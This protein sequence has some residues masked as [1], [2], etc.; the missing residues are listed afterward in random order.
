M[1]LRRGRARAEVMGDINVVSLID[2]MMLLLV[3]FMITA[4]MMQGGIDLTLPTA[5][6][7]PLEAKSS[8]IVSVTRTSVFVDQ[9]ELSDGEFR[10]AFKSMA[11]KRAKDG[12]YLRGD[13]NVTLQRLLNIFSIMRAAGV[14]NI[15]IITEPP[16]EG[17][18]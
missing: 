12:V 6:A 7:K 13:A 3:I 14:E 2:V 17:R 18:Q 16:G 10:A 11:A 9:T 8:L 4:P 5:E 15:G 1:S